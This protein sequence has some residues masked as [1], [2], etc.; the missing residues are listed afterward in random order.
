MV[1]YGLR[2]ISTVSDALHDRILELVAER[3]SLV[4]D[5]WAAADPEHRHLIELGWIARAQPSSTRIIRHDG[6][7]RPRR[8]DLVITLHP[9]NDPDGDPKIVLIVECQLHANID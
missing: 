1:D 2:S 4:L 8:P 6:Q 7:D 3:P 9:A 5:L